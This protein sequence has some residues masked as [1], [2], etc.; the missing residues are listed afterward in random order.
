MPV[1]DMR[2]VLIVEDDD[3]LR[4]VLRLWFDA[5]DRFEVV[6]EATA[7]AT[8]I[9]AARRLQPDFAIMD[10]QLPNGNGEEATRILG[11]VSPSTKVLAYSA[12]V[13]RSCVLD[14]IA[15]G[16]DGY[17]VKSG[18]LD[19]LDEALDAIAADGIYLSRTLGSHLVEH[20]RTST[21]GERARSM[22][23]GRD[24]RI[25]D[26]AL[27]EGNLQIALQPIIELGSNA[28]W[29]HEALARFSHVEGPGVVFAAAARVD[30]STEVELEAARRAVEVV[31]TCSIQ[32]QVLSINAS[33]DALVAPEFESIVAAVD[34]AELV[35]ELTE[36]T[37]VADYSVLGP[38]IE[39]LRRRG[40]RLAIDDVGSGF[41]CLTHVHRLL[42]DIVKIDRYLVAGIH[43][44][45]T[46]RSMMAALVRI[47]ADI[48]ATVV[49]EGIEH[50]GELH[51]LEDLG[52]ELGQGF[53]LGVPAL[54]ISRREGS[55]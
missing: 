9:E 17:V 44:D 4:C 22:P 6:A 30:R 20:L 19:E 35:V 48:G 43:E 5:S 29:G 24:H 11:S 3:D 47:A 49:A 12:S 37:A 15:A 40:V 1:H 42:P 52:V 34:P 46:R 27:E 7:G 39:R 51:T 26:V 31:S 14:M 21:R 41:A 25:V 36:Q 13:E 53:L 50:A 10:V 23:V 38:A 32:G 28:V 2:S 33:P 54:G 55:A 18:H 45:A 16:A 8:A